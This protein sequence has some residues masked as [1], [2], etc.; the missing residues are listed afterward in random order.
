MRPLLK[1]DTF[2][3]PMNDSVYL[4]NNEK[5]LVLK[6]KT[7][8][9]W[10]ERLTPVLDGHND[11]EQICQALPEDKRSVLTKLI[12]TLTEQ[13]YIKDVSTEQPHTLSAE[14]VDT[15]GAAITFINYHTD[16]GGHRFQK[17]LTMPVVAIGSGECL[18]ALAH[19]LLE[20]GNRTISLLDTGEEQTDYERLQE[21]VYVLQSERDHELTLNIIQKDVGHNKEQLQ[22][23]CTNAAMVLYYS[24]GSSLS[25]VHQ[26]N[27]VCQHAYV[28]FLPAVVLNNEIHIGPLHNSEQIGCWQ[29]YWRRW[30]A[31]Q[32]H[33]PYTP[34]GQLLQHEVSKHT[35]HVGKPAIGIAANILALEFF[36][37]STNVHRNTLENK[38]YILELERLQT[39]RHTL[40]PHPLCTVC[41]SQPAFDMQKQILVQEIRELMQ[42]RE[43]PQADNVAQIEQW[44]DV[45]SGIFS[46]IDDMDYHQLP[47]IRNQIT[48]PLATDRTDSLPSVR[49]A[50]LD[51]AEVRMRSVRRAVA[52]YLESLADERRA[53][54]GTYQQL[55][56]DAVKP[57]RL[58]G[59]QY[60]TGVEQIALAWTWAIRLVDGTP[61]LV[62]AA[63]IA[64]RSPWNQSDGSTI[65]QP[66]LPMSSVGTT[67]Y[68]TLA[69]GLCT[70]SS[71]VMVS[72][73]TDRPH[74]EFLLRPIA[75]EAYCTD[76]LC[77]AYMDML[78]VF[79]A[80]VLLVDCVNAFGIPRV[81]TYLNGQLIGISSHW[82]TLCAVRI[83]LQSAVLDVQMRRNPA[84]EDLIVEP[85]QNGGLALLNVRPYPDMSPLTELIPSLADETDYFTATSVLSSRFVQQGWDIIVALL[86]K[87][88]TVSSILPCAL[89]ALAVRRE[90]DGVV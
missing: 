10:L 65:F 56:T 46:R 84:A 16:S 68:E 72:L 79:H 51:Y 17:F 82:N 76:H 44:A 86:A 30:N 39:V 60:T 1:S 80:Q 12:L 3:V 66:E 64:P 59:W 58:F 22:Q 25:Y 24:T 40:F 89:R 55:R 78:N 70:L 28:P 4:R 57:E 83:A 8:A 29:C 18:L 73:E 61:V 27:S 23:L 69:E 32:G 50:G 13:G 42:S 38:V 74:A 48:V 5:S 85:P 33:L 45:N 75:S 41:S 7:L 87:D 11:L 35:T 2:F 9:T 77:A 14:I 88:Q 90:S 71:A 43:T 21:L 67:W 54:W 34:D 19:A 62:P 53:C 26:L 6:G 47:L 63:A 49:A 15:Y 37:A 20:T 81:A 52:W 31:A 36:K